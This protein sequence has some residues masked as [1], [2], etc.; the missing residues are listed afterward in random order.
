MALFILVMFK[1]YRYN[2]TPLTISLILLALTSGLYLEKTDIGKS[3]LQRLNA[4]TYDLRMRATT[5]NKPSGFPPIFII[6]IDEV[7]LEQEGRWPWS[8]KKLAVLIDKLHTAGTA[9]ITLDIT[10][11]EAERNPV[12][13]VKQVVA[14]NNPELSLALNAVRSQLDA[15]KQLAKMLQ[16]KNVI[17]GYLFN[18]NSRFSK[19]E[20]IPTLIQSDVPIQQLTSLI[21][22]GYSANLSLLSRS[23]VQNGFFTV[24]PDDDGV[25]RTASLVLEYNQQLYSALA[26]E[27]AKLYLGADKEKIRLSSQQVADVQAITHLTIAGQKI[28]TD[29]NGRILIP[30]LGKAKTFPYISASDVLHNKKIPDLT[31]SIVIIGTSAHALSDLKTTPLQS[32]FPGVEIQATLIHALL[33]PASIPF[34]PEW[35]D[36]VMVLLLSVLSLIMLLLYPLLRPFSLIIFG[37]CLLGLMIGFNLWLWNIAKINLDMILPALLIILTSSLFV[38]HRL[39]HEHNERERI[40]NMFGQYVPAGHIDRLLDDNKSANMDGERREMS[41]LFSDIRNFTAISEGLSTHQL[42]QF[43]NHYLTPITEIIFKQQG[44]IDKYIGDLVMAFWGAPL[45]DPHHAENAV[46]AALKMR[47]KTASMQSALQDLGITQTVK[48]GI[49]IHTG[50]MN[51][52]DM[53]SSYRRAYTVLGDAV[54][55]GSRLES[56]TKQYGILILTSAATMQQC[57]SIYFRQVDCVRVKGR[58]EP[59][60]IYEPL[61]LKNALTSALNQQIEQHNKALA[62]YLV[63]DWT[64]AHQQFTL[65]ATHYNDPLYQVYLQRMQQMELTPPHDWKGVFT[66]TSK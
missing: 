2:M 65:L 18:Q 34:S 50:E 42:K 3:L 55:L 49:G 9:V 47:N 60:Q 14:Q 1:F 25:V 27:A 6:D 8:R 39:I 33:N 52:G 22:Q 7:S 32:S 21:M 38:M 4:T 63:G 10:F 35:K 17:L 66:H 40:H 53:G 41:V 15:D 26:V 58:Q 24:K 45:D 51:V 64:E 13:A 48:A 5:K 20:I 46:L 56:L 30:Y 29:A 31:D 23:A 19:G 28:R 54:N 44:T 37:F 16:N 62:A 36:A 57:P 11:T 59:V 12:D 61:C 43:L